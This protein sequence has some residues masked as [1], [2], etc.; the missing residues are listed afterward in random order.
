MRV[1]T[2]LYQMI[3]YLLLVHCTVYCLLSLLSNHGLVC[4]ANPNYN[5]SQTTFERFSVQFFLALESI[6]AVA[7]AVAAA[8][9]A[10]VVVVVVV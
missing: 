7:V 4:R 2:L 8:A 9:A 1:F 6:V 10:V 5:Y 3:K